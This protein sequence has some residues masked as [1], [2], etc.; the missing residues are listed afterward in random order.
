[1]ECHLRDPSIFRVSNDELRERQSDMLQACFQYHYENCID[2]QKYCNAR[3]ISPELIRSLADAPKVPLLDSLETLRK[4]EFLS[5]PKESIVAKFSSSGTSG[6]PLLWCSRDQTS[7]DWQG[8]GAIRMASELSDAKAGDTLLMI[9]DIP[10][11]AFSQTLKIYLPK[12]GHKVLIGIKN[13]VAEGKPS[14]APDIGKIRE[15][16]ESS[17]KNKN[18]VGYPFTVA[19]LRNFAF[20]RSL[21]SEGIVM[22]AGGWKPKDTT[23]N[24]ASL[25]RPELEKLFSRT[26]GI[27]P[28]NVRD[29]YGS[30]ELTFGCWECLHIENGETV[31]E[32]HV[33]PWMYALVLDPDTLEP[34]KCGEVGRAAFLD[35]GNHSSPGFVLT[36]DL[37]KL[38]SDDGCE[39]GRSGQIIEHVKRIKEA[40]FRGCSFKVKDK[41][42]SEE[43]LEEKGTPK[44]A[45]GER[46]LLEYLKE[47]S[48]EVESDFIQRNIGDFAGAMEAI[49]EVLRTIEADKSIAESV[50]FVLLGKKLCYKKGK[51]T[52]LDEGEL[53]EAFPNISKDRILGIFSRLE[54]ADLLVR[55][56][57]GGRVQYHF[58][59]KADE[60]GSALFPMIMWGLKWPRKKSTS[61]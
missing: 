56:E 58:T 29:I 49:I 2:Y 27:S 38:V 33:A 11:S 22:T 39:C 34:V 46:G 37:I 50:D 30:T 16:F 47:H 20:V 41:L 53:I 61:T 36:D 1:M 25:Q 9:P 54:Q 5:I 8:I 43:Y 35:F 17:A 12:A 4:R 23:T 7:L 44:E 51:V 52:V 13:A 59:K 3:G 28:E 60:L 32:K 21:G 48:L 40:G 15:F 45:A 6:S 57:T 31:K 26:F 14:F 10:Q 18:V 42:F 19:N 55:E 24:Y